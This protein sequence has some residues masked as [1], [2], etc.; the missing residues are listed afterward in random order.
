MERTVY[1]YGAFSYIYEAIARAY[2]LG[3]IPRVKASQI[4]ELRPGARVLYIGVGAGEDAL[5][6][7]RAGAQVT[8]LDASPRMLARLRERLDGDDGPA[9]S[10]ELVLGDLFEY[11]PVGRFDVVVANFVLNLYA[12]PQMRRALSRLRGWL[13]PGGRVMIADF[14]LPR[15]SWRWLAEIYYRPVNWVAWLLG[16]CELHPIHDYAAAFPALDLECVSRA[17]TTPFGIGPKLFESIVAR[18]LRR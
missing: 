10:Y 13:A 1:D 7:V 9:C 16:L 14:A 3:A 4:A 11:E 18:D 6:A 12:E 5:L 8:A 15:A 2:S 17:G